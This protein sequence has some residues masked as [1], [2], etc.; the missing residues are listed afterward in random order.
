MVNRF[1]L[2]LVIALV[3][4]GLNFTLRPD[5]VPNSDFINPSLEERAQNRV[6]FSDDASGHV[7]RC[8]DDNRGGAHGIS[9]KKFNPDC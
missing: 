4:I 5:T 3:H 1:D 8:P 2:F 7:I 6:V 9:I